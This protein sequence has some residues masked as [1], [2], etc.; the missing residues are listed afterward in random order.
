MTQHGGREPNRWAAMLWRNLLTPDD[1]A[2]QPITAGTVSD[3]LLST[4]LKASIHSY[5]AV[6]Y[7]HKIYTH[8]QQICTLDILYKSVS[9][10]HYL[11]RIDYA[12]KAEFQAEVK[13]VLSTKI[14]YREVD[15][16]QRLSEPQL[17]VMATTCMLSWRSLGEHH[18]QQYVTTDPCGGDIFRTRPNRPPGPPR[19]L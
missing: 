18:S 15:V 3:L 13:V 12:W 2:L 16:K 1:T 11:F 19:H 7:V 5:Q 14:T 6:Q 10:T 8:N 9:K 17:P 4:V